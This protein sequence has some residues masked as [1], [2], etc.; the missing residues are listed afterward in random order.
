MLWLLPTDEGKVSPGRMSIVI[1]GLQD[2]F[3]LKSHLIIE[4]DIITI[5]TK[6]VI[7]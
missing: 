7:T 4:F 3:C 2:R 1:A 5:H 6:I